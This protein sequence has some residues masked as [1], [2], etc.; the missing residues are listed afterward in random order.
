MT[1]SPDTQDTDTAAC[2]L[3]ADDEPAPFWTYNAEAESDLLLVCDHAANFVPRA[4]DGLG[5]PARALE[6]HIAY[7][8]GIAPVTRMMADALNAPAVFS[9]FSRLIVDPNRQLDDPT[10]TPAIADETVVPGN[11][12]LS[13]D[14]LEARL[15]SFFWP[16]HGA[17]ARQLDA[18]T[19]RGRA[20]V[21]VSMHSFTPIL[22]GRERPW[23]IGV[24]WDYDPRLPVPLMRRA[25]ARGWQVGDNE[26]YSARDGHGYTQ[27][28]HGD[29]RGLANALVEIRQDLIDT[30]RGQRAWADEMVELLRPLL[31]DPEL[32]KP[33]RQ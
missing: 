23:Q 21:L 2:P 10:L 1:R 20:P 16:Y 24:L 33:Y 29:K 11:R 31:D 12:E 15:Q 8:I 30:Q 7:D 17:V 19:A 26:P 13:A 4:L 14:A 3:L 6:R 28:V 9:H 32:Y 27:H 22:R 18:M 5:V 25:R